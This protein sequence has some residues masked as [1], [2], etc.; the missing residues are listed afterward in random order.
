MVVDIAELGVSPAHPVML[1]NAKGGLQQSTISMVVFH[2]CILVGTFFSGPLS[3]IKPGL[4]FRHFVLTLI[5][6]TVGRVVG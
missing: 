6:G 5:E 4:A 3:L 2:S 1:E